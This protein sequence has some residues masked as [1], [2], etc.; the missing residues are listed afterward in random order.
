VPL[1]RGWD[2]QVDLSRN[3]LLY[4]PLTAATYHTWL[5]ENAVRFVALPDAPLDQGGQAEKALLRHPPTYLR[6]V[7]AD[8]QWHIWEVVEAAP[9]ASGAATMSALSASSFTLMAA[10]AGITFVRLRWSNY[11][12][13]DGKTV[14]CVAPAG[15]GWTTV[16][17]FAPGPIKVSAR[18]LPGDTGC[19]DQELA[20]Y[21]LSDRGA[22]EPKS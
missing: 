17:S 1:A 4:A 9:L 2:R 12:H 13:I 3:A 15:G 19:T 5:I 11:W 7:Y 8:N 21:G 22:P 14:A 18:A 6:L 10:S 16:L 20:L